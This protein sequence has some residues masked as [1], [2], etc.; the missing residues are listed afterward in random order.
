MRR[1]VLRPVV[2]TAL[3]MFGAAAGGPLAGEARLAAQ[4]PTAIP[5][6]AAVPEVAALAE[7]RAVYGQIRKKA[8]KTLDL[9]IEGAISDSA[10]AGNHAETRRLRDVQDA[11]R[12]THQIPEGAGPAMAVPIERY[13][14]T[15]RV[16]DKF[17]DGC[18]FEAMGV[19]SREK[20]TDEV[21]RLA[22]E[23]NAWKGTT[24]RPAPNLP[25]ADPRPPGRIPQ[26]TP[27]VGAAPGGPSP[28][29]GPRSG[30]GTPPVV[31]SPPRAGIVD[32]V[33]PAITG[34]GK[35]PMPPGSPAKGEPRPTIV[36]PAPS[37][38]ATHP[39]TDLEVLHATWGVDPR[40]TSKVVPEVDVTPLVRRLIQGDPVV[41]STAVFGDLKEMGVTRCLTL[42]LRGEGA[43]QFS[44]RLHEGSEVIA[45]EL[46]PPLDKTNARPIRGT[47]LMLMLAS[48]GLRD[49]DR[50][51]SVAA[52]YAARFGAS[53]SVAA[54]T[55]VFGEPAFTQPKVLRSMWRIGHTLLYVKQSENSEVTVE[56]PPA[57]AAPPPPKEVP[58]PTP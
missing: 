22:A 37:I 34:S 46:T 36:L 25:P 15:M 32:G 11:F 5:A 24:D 56:G 16:A 49:D 20:R 48:W 52:E 12:K 38:E 53:K 44:L 39:A 55:T 45:R 14:A 43:T 23:R 8:Q 33:P 31:V 19:L 1:R 7:A 57:N 26:G 17:L 41:V 27:P 21:Q 30:S 2:V 28:G 51:E 6:E 18:Y 10:G 50:G 54:S 29:T 40:Y 42:T 13:R 4:V 9:A 35:V 58:I 47:K 3:V